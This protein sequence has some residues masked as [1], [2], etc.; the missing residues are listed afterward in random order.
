MNKIKAN[1]HL[2][3]ASELEQQKIEFPVTFDLKAVM[4]ESENDKINTNNLEVVFK[5][6]DVVHKYLHK[7][8]SSKGTYSSYTYQ[9]T[10]ENKKQMESMYAALK[11][12]EGLKFAL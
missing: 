10:L 7:K 4:Q 3:S 1:G 8:V 12:V 6:L 2:M 5:K 9:V 11:N